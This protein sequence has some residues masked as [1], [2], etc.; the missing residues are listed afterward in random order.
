MLRFVSRRVIWAIP[1]LFIVTFLVFVAI[2]VGT[3]PV[4]AYARANSH[5]TPAQI[6]QFKEKNG[7]DGLDLPAVLHVAG[8]LR[9]AVTGACSIVGQSPRVADAEARDGQHH[10]P[11]AVRLG[12]RHHDRAGHR[13]PVARCKQHSAFDNGASAGAFVGLSIPPYI[14][15]ILLQMLFAVYLTQWLGLSRVRCCRRRGST[16]P[17]TRA[18]TRCCG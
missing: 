7:L 8:P 1:T 17:A 18:S 12:H 4:K 9:H 15:A 16:R 3:D 13:H 10:R 2:R 14:S 5:V 11:R 6:A